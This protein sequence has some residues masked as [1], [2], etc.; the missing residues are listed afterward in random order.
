MLTETDLSKLVCPHPQNTSAYNNTVGALKELL[1]LM[2][3]HV[4]K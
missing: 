3:L 4:Y 2:W 1:P